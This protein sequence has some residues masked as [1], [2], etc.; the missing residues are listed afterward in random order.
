MM[1]IRPYIQD[2]YF[3]FASILSEEDLSALSTD[4][5]EK[6]LV[7]FTGGMILEIAESKLNLGNLEDFKFFFHLTNACGNLLMS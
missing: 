4:N 1:T 5:I 7:L 6:K 3:N 2:D